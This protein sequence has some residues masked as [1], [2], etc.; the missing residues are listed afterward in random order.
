MGSHDNIKFGLFK[1]YVVVVVLV[2]YSPS[3][4]F[5]S[6][7]SQLTYP[8]CSWTSLLGSLPVLGAYFFASSCPSWISRRKRMA[9]KLFH[10]QSPRKNVAGHASDQ[11]TAPGFQVLMPVFVT[12]KLHSD[13]IKINTLCPEQCQIWLF[14]RSRASNSVVNMPIWR[15]I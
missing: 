3:T 1:S 11:T 4:L 5:R 10:D 12:W 9:E 7:P 15:K 2:F 14:Q 8:H 13:L 6:F